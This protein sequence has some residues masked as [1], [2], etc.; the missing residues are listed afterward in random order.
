VGCAGVNWIPMDTGNWLER[1][2]GPTASGG[3]TRSR[4]RAA[5]AV[6]MATDVLQFVLGPLGWVLADEILDVIALVATTWLLGFH[7]LLL[8]TF[9]LELVPLVDM[10]P[11][12]T[13]CV[14]LVVAMRKKQPPPTIRGGDEPATIDVKP[15]SVT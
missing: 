11:T 10:V 13:A 14:A 1:L 15:T 12:W 9:V 6:A 4:I 5:Y 7:P 3:L 8:P 2:V